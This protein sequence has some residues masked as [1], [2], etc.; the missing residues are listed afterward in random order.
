MLFITLIAIIFNLYNDVFVII[1]DVII[2]HI[3]IN[4]VVISHVVISHVVIN[5]VFG[6]HG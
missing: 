3:V 1:N 5:D 6:I 4:D 2:N